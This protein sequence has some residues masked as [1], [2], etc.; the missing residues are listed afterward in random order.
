MSQSV[1][2]IGSQVHKTV[3]M[4]RKMC[5]SKSATFSSLSLAENIAK[6]FSNLQFLSTQMKKR[7]RTNA[8][9]DKDILHFPHIEKLGSFTTAM[10]PMLYQTSDI[11]S[12]DASDN[13][14]SK[15][16]RVMSY[17]WAKKQHRPRLVKSSAL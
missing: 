14:L 5:T 3:D 7:Q 9:R 4:H 8:F 12:S 13:A 1:S 17:C 2:Q 10:C 16:L 11:F 6:S 15:Q